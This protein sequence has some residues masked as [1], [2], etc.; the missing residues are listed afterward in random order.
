MK[1]RF[2]STLLGLAALSG[3]VV[4]PNYQKPAVA[5]PVKHRGAD[6]SGASMADKPWR[7]V[8]RDPVLRDLIDEGLRNN[9]DLVQAT[10]R[11]EQAAAGAGAAQS[12]FFPWLDG[13]ASAARTKMSEPMPGVDPRV[14]QFSLKGSLSWELDLWGRIRRSNE[15]AR[16]RLVGTEYG[17]ATVQTGL[18]A[19][20]ASAYADLRT[21]DRQLEIARSTLES[22]RKSLGLVQER[23]KQ[24]VSSDLEVGQAEVLLRQAEVRVPQTEQAIAITED[25][26][27][28]LLG[29]HPG[30]VARGRTLESFDGSLRLKA[31]L[32]SHLLETRPDI[33]SAE[34]DLVAANAEIGV[35]KAAYFPALRLT[36][37]DGF[38]S[39][40]L[41]DLFK[42]PAHTWSF[43]PTLAGPI[44]NAGRIHF[45]V[46]SAEAE[47]KR[48]VAAYQGTI[49]QAFREAADSIITYDK[50]GQVVDRQM[51]LVSSLERVA[52]L[53]ATRYQGGASSYLEVLDAERNLFDGQLALT[54]ARRT[55]LKAVVQAY[56]ALGGGWDRK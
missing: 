8:F 46:K 35:A 56:R 1:I 36:G 54:E 25:L 42:G 30:P 40:Q 32:P 55:R 24:G 21:Y 29:R 44:F 53:A 48:L 17:R 43:A 19:S 6:E 37:S 26:I 38:V 49:Q 52:S 31:G 10:Y 16:A 39:G 50:A 45:S 27:C 9:T 11:I 33:L 20:V 7:E 18:V 34:Q 5:V 4:G 22:R 15:A 41:E 51:A 47:Q 2:F 12:E 28:V 23:A 14:N 13:S 3:C